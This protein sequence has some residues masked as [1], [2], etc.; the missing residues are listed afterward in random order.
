M[1]TI[2]I[3]CV[4]VWREISNYLDGE[5]T[6]PLYWMGRETSWG[7]LATE[8]CFRC[9]KDLI[10][11]CTKRFENYHLVRRASKFAFRHGIRNVLIIDVHP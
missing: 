11:V 3:S 7:W 10:N 6:A 5:I 1:P 8:R 9:R 2:E 4:E